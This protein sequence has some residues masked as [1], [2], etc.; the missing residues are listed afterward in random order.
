MASGELGV[1]AV[2][3]QKVTLGSL[4]GAGTVGA[5][6]IARSAPASIDYVQ[7]AASQREQLQAQA[8]EAE[9]LQAE[10][11]EVK[12]QLARSEAALSGLR[13]DIVQVRLDAQIQGLAEAEQKNAEA[14]Q[15]QLDGVAQQWG[16]GLA[17]LAQ[18]HATYCADLT[19][20]LG[21]LALAAVANILGEQ[22]AT[23]A[24]IAQG[25]DHITRASGEL[26]PLTVRVAP[27]HYAQLQ[28]LPSLKLG[29]LREQ[30]V[31]LV[32]DTRVTHGGCLLETASG[33][34]DARYDIQLNKLRDIV[35]AG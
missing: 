2:V 9:A 3:T 34:V 26:G 15:L 4:A 13:E 14:L 23:P 11:L 6:S 33:I 18:Q 27:S 30:R 20:Q 32:P 5:E 10:L 16:E 12:A 19:A 25:I 21:D 1:D 28:T 17:E 8:E 7:L 24:A 31:E 29:L 22:L 35:R